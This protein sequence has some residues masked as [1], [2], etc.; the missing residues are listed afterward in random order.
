MLALTLSIGL[1]ATAQGLE[2][3]CEFKQ[4]F[5]V[6][7]SGSAGMDTLIVE[8]LGETCSAATVVVRIIGLR[9]QVIIADAFALTDVL[10]DRRPS[11]AEARAAVESGIFIDQRLYASDLPFVDNKPDGAQEPGQPLPR[12]QPTYERARQT[13]GPVICWNYYHEGQRCAWWDREQWIGRI[14][15]EAGY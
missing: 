5:Q 15:Y 9:N 7:M 4:E 13:G 8:T 3:N 12:W 11:R 14:L 1:L 10:N 6:S 2:E